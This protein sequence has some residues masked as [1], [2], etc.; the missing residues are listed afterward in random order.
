MTAKK[1][2]CFGHRGA[3]G[4]EPENTVRSVRRA[5]ELGADGV[6]VDVYFVDGQLVVIHDDTLERTT[7]GRGRVTRKSFAYLRSLDAGMGE[8]IP[9]L[10]EI[11]AAVNRRG[12]INIEIKGPHT[13][14]PVAALMA[15]QVNHGGWNFG[16]FL[17]SSFDHAQLIETKQLQPEIPIGALIEKTRRGLV[18]FAE[19]LGAWSIHAGKRCVTADLVAESHRHGLKVFAYT[20]NR[21]E[22]ITRMK[23]LGVDG[24]FSDFPE[25]LAD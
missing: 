4:H 20:I 15:E 13:A 21:P 10:L 18:Q 6:E 16:D 12:I 1:L 11:F 17:V 24:V 14:A 9:T 22:E 7:N 8:C 25:R 19:D 23:M 2:F 5:L 3:S